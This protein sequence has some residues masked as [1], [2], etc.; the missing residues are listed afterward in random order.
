MNKCSLLRNQGGVICGHLMPILPKDTPG[1]TP[2]VSYCIKKD[3]DETPQGLRS[4][5]EGAP[6]N[7]PW[8]N[9]PEGVISDLFR[10]I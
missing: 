2:I 3:S 7:T 9:V 10:L 1:R 6:W 4:G 5:P 8:N